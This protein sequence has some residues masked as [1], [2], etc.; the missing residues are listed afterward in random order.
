MR[1]PQMRSERHLRE[2]GTVS[3]I[4]GGWVLYGIFR[5]NTLFAYFCVFMKNM[6][7]L[8]DKYSV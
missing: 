1:V 4:K 7:C 3:P 2:I 5:K 8:D 6:T